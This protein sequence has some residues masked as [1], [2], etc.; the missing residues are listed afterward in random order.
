M[1]ICMKLFLLIAALLSFCGCDQNLRFSQ[2]NDPP[3]VP[4]SPPLP[5]GPP[6]IPTPPAPTPEKYEIVESGKTFHFHS[7]EQTFEQEKLD[8]NETFLSFQVQRSDGSLVGDLSADAFTFTENSQPIRHFNFSK[9]SVEY[10]QTVDIVFTV[11]VTGSMA[12]TIEAAKLSLID[13]IY[14]SRGA[15]YH[16]RMCLVTFGDFT[17]KKCNKFYDNNP[18]DPSTLVQVQELISE[19]TKLKALTGA[20]DPGGL[21]MEENPLQA[22]IDASQAPWVTG[23]QR[24]AILI[25]DTGFLYSPTQQ[26]HIGASAPFW[27]DFRSVLLASQMKVFAATPPLPGYNQKFKKQPGLIELSQ[28][29]WFDFAD[30]VSGRIT[31]DS[32]LNR[33]LIHVNT[34]YVTKYVAEEQDGLDA[35]LPLQ[36]RLIAA[37]LN[38]KTLGEIIGTQVQSNLPE[39]R[40]EYSKIFK[41]SDK[42][43][44]P[45]SLR[46]WIND[47]L[48][49]VFEL[50]QD[51]FI[52]FPRAPLPG[53]KIKITYEYQEVQDSLLLEPFEID[54]SNLDQTFE[55]TLNSILVDASYYSRQKI[56]ENK[57]SLLLTD[58]I[59]SSDD[60]FRIKSLKKLTVL[61]RIKRLVPTDN[62][63]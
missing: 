19:I 47:I 8:K 22:L 62:S 57:I 23:D 26:G 42:K 63:L 20:A 2:V 40:K 51:N 11:D 27:K 6:P 14:K 12:P 17:I 41:I 9:N 55:V 1:K 39:G 4:P 36:R 24:F 21:D 16:S 7:S 29:E 28:G 31:L 46:V 35:T 34:T 18:K 44:A 60:P 5:P 56:A 49:P 54:V 38:N 32:I 30:L 61:I 3:I 43:I 52:E 53:A 59:F 45:S 25:T 13:F 58:R 48:V 33:I 15:G 10:A 37:T 50:V